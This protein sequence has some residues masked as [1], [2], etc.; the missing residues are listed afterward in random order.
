MS[1]LKDRLHRVIVIGATPAGIAATNKLGEL[2][3]PVTLVD[4][5]PDL[6][7]KL[8]KEEWR[9]PSGLPL[10][11]AQRS[12]LIRIMRNPAIQCLLPAR[13]EALKHTPQGF[14]ARIKQFQT[15]VD[16]ARCILCGRCTEVCPVM[17]D[18]GEKAIQ[19]SGRRVL[20]GRAVIDKR[21][22]PLCQ[23][24]C[25]LGVNA[26]AYIALTRAGRYREALAVV[27]KENILPGICGRICTHPCEGECRRGELDDPIAIR[28]IKRFLADYER[29]HPADAPF[30]EFAAIAPSEPGA[31]IHQNKK[32]AVIGSG[33]AGLAAAAE[34]ARFGYGVT[35]Y[36]KEPLA[37]GFLRYAI[38]P[39]RLPRDI[40]D[41]ELAYIEKL[42]VTIK[43]SHPVDLSDLK[44]GLVE[45]ADAVLVATGAWTDR[46]LGV[47]GEDLK[48]VDGCIQVLNG[49][50][51]DGAD[52]E[53]GGNAA[54]EYRGKSVAVIGDGNAAFDL[55]RVLKRLGAHVT[56]LS[57]FPEDFI[58]ADPEEVRGA[59]EEGIPVKNCT[60]VVAFKGKDGMLSRL[61]C[62]PTVPGP[63][64]AN[65]IPWP[66]IV[67]GS[68]AF[69]LPFDRAIVAI[70][71]MGTLQVED[72][73]E[74]TPGGFAVTAGGLMTVDNE[75]RTG[76]RHV[77]ASGDGVTGPSSV[78]QAMAGG[79]GAARAIHMDLSGQAQIRPE[80]LRPEERAFEEIPEDIPS[81]ARAVMA[82]RQPAARQG[83]FKEVALGL[84]ES[85]VL[86]ESER[87]LQC[88]ICSE[89]LLCKEVCEA[90]GAVDHAQME[91]T[92]VEHAGVVIIAD[93]GAAPPVKGEDVIRAYGPKAAK[94][95]VNAMMTRGFAAAAQAMLLL[96]GTSQGLRGRGVSFMPPDP[97]LAP[98][99]R[100][101]VFVCQ[102]NESMGWLD[103]MSRYVEQLVERDDVVYT[104]IM[105]AACV[106]EGS[107]G[108]LRAIRE[109][110]LTRVVLASCVCCPLD[111]VC[112]AC[113]D[114]RSR[115]KTALF[116]GTGVSRS[117]VETCNLR[118]EILRH[119]RG[120]WK[121]ALR[122]FEGIIGRSIDRARHLKALPSPMR[123]YNFATAVIGETEAAV[124]SAISLASAGF[125]VLA[126]GAGERSLK[127][128]FTHP[129]IHSFEGSTVTGLSGTLGDFQ[130]HVK[131]DGFSQLLQVG[132]IILDERS[133]RL[134]PYLPQEGLDTE[135]LTFAPQE[136]G[137]PGTPF[138]YPGVSPIA[139]LFLASP[140]GM[141]V[142]QR[143]RGRRRRCLPQPSCRGAR[144]RAGD[145]PWWWMKTAVAG[146]A[147][148]WPPA[149]TGQCPFR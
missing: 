148:V 139:G 71:Q 14:R 64:D 90:I 92:L 88:G 68:D 86:N 119:I 138:N 9:L 11:F 84:S 149:P 20:P 129:N 5:D 121:Q 85:R 95:D 96:R 60:Q 52:R 106:P 111:F 116:Q 81:V 33:P 130:V 21:M 47:P 39:H 67:E 56:L 143:K 128:R 24:G 87:C 4:E 1:R 73:T 12:G 80:T 118:G 105:S 114:Q 53:G 137:V 123:T 120:D 31:G 36:E 43:T 77:Y 28:D 19:I 54:G 145:I 2:D 102:C 82:E 117:M 58:P 46:K 27:R 32:I 25:P 104:E 41:R 134:I 50:Y 91:E 97:E 136:R 38:G 103:E 44:D 15:F 26:Q 83:N 99:I 127:A 29:A 34:L 140:P 78:V 122:R 30:S 141:S 142:S 79:K 76:I 37:G 108:I 48:E 55:V 69:E 8:G 131:T 61:K 59:M 42:G 126:F 16:P 113:T 70:G 115:L 124:N 146:A 75:F 10:N 98:D 74:K 63:P 49:L 7:R 144:D 110:G 66:V 135:I 51:R 107:A 40:L 6:D 17:T 109:K 125:E 35:V 57:W 132:T 13:V 23:A 22:A 94:S 65:G 45:N 112:S 72:E 101:G 62:K 133:R 18:D 89:C 100:M 93:P 3:I 147:D